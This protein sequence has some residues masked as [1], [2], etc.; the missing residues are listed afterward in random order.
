M[1]KM[2]KIETPIKD[3]TPLDVTVATQ[4][5]LEHK[6]ADVINSSCRENYSNTPDYILADFM[7]RCLQAFEIASNNREDWFGVHLD[8][9][10]DWNRLIMEAIG[11]ASMCWSEIPTG[12][13]DS[14][15][16]IKIGEKLLQDIKRRVV[17]NSEK[18]IKNG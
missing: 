1:D 8:I 15:R 9:L 5:I 4:E 16:A 7:V 17:F 14:S 10:N 18:G 6:I 12:V 2:E 11:E 13:F 3:E